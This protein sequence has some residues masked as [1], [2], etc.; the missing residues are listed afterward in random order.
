MRITTVA[1]RGAETAVTTPAPPLAGAAV[2]PPRRGPAAVIRTGRDRLAGQLRGPMVDWLGASFRLPSRHDPAPHPARLAGICAWAAGLGLVG[3]PVAGRISVA[4]VT[5]GAPGW[6]EPTV[7][8]VGVLG[9]VLTVAA[10]AAI[11]RRWLPWLL[12]AVATVPL[13]VNLTLAWR[14]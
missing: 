6:F 8:T 1:S 5:N 14:L 12:L 7:V 3:L 10:F 2:P 13:A 9:I 4:I 11:H